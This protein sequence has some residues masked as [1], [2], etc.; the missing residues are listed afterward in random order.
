M[1]RL[2]QLN[3]VLGEDEEKMLESLK[4]WS[5]LDASSFVRQEILLMHEASQSLTYFEVRGELGS[6]VRRAKARKHAARVE[7]TGEVDPTR[8]GVVGEM[9]RSGH[10][11]LPL[12]YNRTK[13]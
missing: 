5:G 4:Q 7:S 13:K 11:R 2:K 10:V 6:A 9:V 8:R 3:V 12:P 1:K